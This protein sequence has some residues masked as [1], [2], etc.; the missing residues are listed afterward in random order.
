MVHG[1]DL[2]DVLRDHCGRGARFSRTIELF[3]TGDLSKATALVALVGISWSVA[4]WAPF[5]I[6]MEVR[7]EV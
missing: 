5:A 6:I 7:E 4:V 3:L 2:V 1:S